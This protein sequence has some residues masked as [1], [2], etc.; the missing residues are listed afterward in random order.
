MSVKLIT[1]TKEQ[2]TWADLE[3]GVIIH[4]DVQ[5]FQADYSFRQQWGYQPPAETFA[6]MDLDTDQWVLSA[7]KA[8]AKYAVLVAKHC[9]GFCLWPTRCHEYSV[10][11]SPWKNGNGDIVA[12]FFASCKKYDV[13]P[14]LYYSA[15]CNAYCN[16]DNPGVIQNKDG[17][18]S[19]DEIKAAQ[20][21]YNNMVIKQLTELW[22]NYG[23]I[24]EIWFDGGC[25]PVEQG[26]PDIASL[27]HKLQ[28]NA[29][30][31]QGPP[32][33]KSLLRWVGN[34]RATAPEDCYATVDFT[35]ESFDGS[36]ERTYGGN[37]YGQTWSP[38][39]SDIPNRY[40]HKSFMGGWFWKEG[41]EDAIIPADVLFDTY[42]KSV[43]RNTNLLIGMV[44]DNKGLFPDADAKVFEQF[45]CL[46]SA[47]FGTPIT[48]IRP[49]ERI[50]DYTFEI[51]AGKNPKYLV[52]KE[53]I[54]YGERILGL[55]VTT[56]DKVIEC[57]S[58]GHKRILPL[59]DNAKMINILITESKETPIIKAIEVY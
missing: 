21:I 16:V 36:D 47:A 17:K 5:T 52:I 6:P 39:E 15:S 19:A 30:V 25:L 38:A 55:K 29:L 8:G 48:E 4:M 32:G 56:G 42:L 22:T 45:G 12:D 7:K 31:F 43:G 58:V 18:L 35:A 11:N 33:T 44:I 20:E 14:G 54:K 34:E 24:F 23:D 3:I 53:D 2:H 37:P 40:A 50:N 51:P 46:V 10:K 27:L 28:P 26:G 49:V 9:S 1:P 41:E 59:P 57:K 13:K